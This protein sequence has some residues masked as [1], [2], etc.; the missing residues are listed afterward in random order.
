LSESKKL[1][2]CIVSCS[3]LQKEIQQLQRQGNLDADVVFVDKYYH[4]DYGLLEQNL[5]HT[6]EEAKVRPHGKL[7]LV[8]G[9]FCLGPNGEMKQLAAQYGMIKV[10]AHNCVDCLLGGKGKIVQADPTH[11]IMFF[12]RGMIEFFQEMHA[13]LKQE[14]M[15]DDTFKR[16]FAGLKGIVVLDTLG[17]A[18]KSRAEV[19]A[20][21]TGLPIL[22]VREVGLENVK[23]VI[24]EAIQQS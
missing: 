23:R 1:K 21:R 12:D 2:P 3:V 13:K 22:E 9:D 6:I 18:E 16:M 7:I 17:E 20:L 24:C 8:Y 5:R 15:D 10:D 14:G 19:E 4:I 11:E